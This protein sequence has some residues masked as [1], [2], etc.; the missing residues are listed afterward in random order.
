[1]NIVYL[2]MGLSALCAL[3]YGSVLVHQRPSTLRTIVKAASVASLATIGALC[4]AP[5]LLTAALVLGTIGDVFLSREG[6]RNFLFGLGAFLIGHMAYI[7]LL[8]GYGGSCAAFVSNPLLLCASA[9]LFITA[10]LITRRLFPYLGALRMPVLIYVLVIVVMGVCAL[11]VP[12][13]W[14]FAL[15]ILGAL[16]FIASDAILGFE[17][18]VFKDATGP[19]HGPAKLLWFLYWGGQSL[20][21]FSFLAAI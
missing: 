12:A 1:M 13:K 2:V 21:L 16:M 19:R 9:A 3:A 20:I 18:F 10:G 14:P 8:I 5:M 17:V 15:T 7:G 11:N 6:E 4:G